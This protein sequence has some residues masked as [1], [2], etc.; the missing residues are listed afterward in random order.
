[1]RP[2]GWNAIRRSRASL[3]AW[4]ASVVP[5]EAGY[6]AGGGQY[7][8]PDAVQGEVTSM[9][10]VNDPAIRCGRSPGGRTYLCPVFGPRWAATV[11]QRCWRGW[12]I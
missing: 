9:R 12:P 10:P 5:G 2:A 4:P 3:L 8:L 1:V 11:R 7:S 6:L